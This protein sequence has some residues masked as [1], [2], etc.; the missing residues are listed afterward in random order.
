MENTK[1]KIKD[2]LQKKKEIMEQIK[3]EKENNKI[4]RVKELI[5]KLAKIN[6]EYKKEKQFEHSLHEMIK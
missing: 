5:A 3:S 1:E 4:D 6:C 2:L